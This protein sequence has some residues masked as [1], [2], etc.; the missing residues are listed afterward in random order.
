M[1]R[2]QILALL[3]CILLCAVVYLFASTKKAKDASTAPDSAHVDHP[4]ESLD[5]EAYL[6]DITGKIQNDSVR[7]K[8]EGF[9]NAHNYDALLQTFSRLDKPLAVAYYMVLKAESLN[10]DTDWILAGDYNSMLMQ[11]A[12]D[13][14]A[15]TYL[16]ENAL[17]SYQKAVA[18]DSTNTNY[19]IRLASAYIENG[20][21]PM[22]GVS[23]LLDIVQKDSN[24]VAAQL[25]LS[26]FG[27]I[28]GQNE[29][30]IARLEKI[31]YLQPQNSEALLMLAEANN[32]LG[33]KEK[34][35]ELL[36]KCKKTVKS[37]ELKSEIDKYIQSIKKPS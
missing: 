2:N 10:T 33:N 31:L 7:K 20:S 18:L 12:P 24:N 11:S 28:S 25:M 6:T 4:A 30:A 13:D 17:K 5:I 36:E 34:A 37:P 3:S 35:L 16:S 19:R 22:Q 23:M 27:L 26:R 21:Q 1:N 8:V 14:K 15:H 29:K 32:N 9:Q